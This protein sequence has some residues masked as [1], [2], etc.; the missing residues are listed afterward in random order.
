MHALLRVAPAS[1][2]YP[3][4][5]AG[6]GPRPKRAS[7]SDR[8]LPVLLAAA[9]L[10]AGCASVGPQLPMS[11]ADEPVSEELSFA[12][13]TQRANGEFELLSSPQIARRLESRL[14]DRPLSILAL[15]S[16]GADGAFGAGALAGAAASG[17]RRE[18]TVV[19]GVSAGAL[20]APFAFLGPSWD[21][22]M[23]RIF[24]TGVTDRVLRRRGLG[25]L[26]GPSVYSGE[27]L[28]Q[29]IDR[30]ADSAMIAAI[31]TQAAKG[32]LLLVATTDLSAG[33]PVI[34]DIGS[35]ALHGGRAA[36]PL[37]R[38]IL[39]A[40]ASVPGIFPPVV[41]KLR[42]GNKMRTETHV[43]GGVTL[44]FFIAPAPRDMPRSDQ[45]GA[46][47]TLV[48]VIVDGKLR[49]LP[50]PTHANA[51]SIFRRS[52]SAGLSHETRAQLE[53]TARE[54]RERGIALRYAAIPA[55]YPL[56]GSLDFSADT[57]RSLFE[58]AAS[59]AAAG[60][61]W[62]AVSPATVAEAS[63][64]LSPTGSPICPADDTFFEQ[65]AAL[66]D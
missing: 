56:A 30:Y 9:L 58:Y 59:C 33:E 50:S 60:R 17:A 57:Q 18:Y 26:F 34:W 44:P 25:A 7:G 45:S 29:L 37:I 5:G 32:R 10:L 61:L 2:E 54:L 62:I 4:A 1:A 15:S 66:K 24:T 3:L 20:V 41:V 14:G 22:K 13:R 53:T 38:S 36:K 52:L 64:L 49:N 51:L 27:P 40:S 48:R 63:T 43:D 12:V 16:G 65:L 28:R 39:L 47:P 31:A 23:S 35:I 6:P 55:S 8:F 11:K 42:R 19:T 21:A 46:R